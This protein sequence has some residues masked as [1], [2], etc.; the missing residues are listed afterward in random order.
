VSWKRLA[1]AL[2]SQPV[3]KLVGPLALLV[4]GGLA[5]LGWAWWSYPVP[6]LRANTLLTVRLMAH[7]EELATVYGGHRASQHW[8]PIE[9]M[10]RFLIDAVLTAEDR[11]FFTHPGLDLLASLRAA[12]VNM[13]QSEVVQGA[14][15]ITQQLARTLFLTSERTW[16]RKMREAIL[17]IQIEMGHPKIGILEAYLNSV[18][19]G[20]DGDVAVHGVAAAARHFLGK[21]LATIRLE[22]A[23]LL[24]AAIRAPNRIL[25]GDAGRARARR[26]VLLAAMRAQGLVADA[27]AREAMARPLRR[28]M[29]GAAVRAPYFSEMALAELTRRTTLPATGEFRIATTL[30]LPL[31]RAAEAAVQEGLAHLERR[32]P[33]SL[34]R[35]QASLVAIEPRSGRIRA[36]VGGRRYVESPFNRA[37]APCASRGRSSSRSSTWPRSRPSAGA[38]PA[39]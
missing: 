12:V 26:N 35:L 25:A 38:T 4:V 6:P 36:L 34:G 16:A 33:P 32:R 27:A 31:Q 30:D 1:A 18:Y 5:T 11:R 37:F 10:P 21:D 20:H 3:K 24:A 39:G 9:T 14:S 28:Q 23:A 8:V 19:M 7:D 29:A 17:A 15:T 22:E 13:R 2:L